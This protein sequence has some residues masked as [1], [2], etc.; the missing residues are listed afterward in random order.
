MCGMS[1]RCERSFSSP[2]D[3]RS[4]TL[5]DGIQC[6]SN[7]GIIYRTI[8][9]GLQRFN[10]IALVTCIPQVKLRQNFGHIFFLSF[11]LFVVHRIF[12]SS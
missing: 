10:Y 3:L 4:S 6:Y 2:P 8:K 9:C 7:S 11:N 5:S 12:I 1:L